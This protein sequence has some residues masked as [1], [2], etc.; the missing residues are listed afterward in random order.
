M[1]LYHISFKGRKVNAFG[2]EIRKI[3]A[4]V[5]ADSIYDVKP[6]IEE[7]YEFISGFCVS[8]CEFF[9]REVFEV[10]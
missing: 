4:V 7:R 2:K 5:S 3:R 1:G 6:M 8:N 10:A 9:D